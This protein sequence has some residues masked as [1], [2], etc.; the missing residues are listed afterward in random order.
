MSEQDIH[1]RLDR[2][3]FK[4]RLLFTALENVR[5]LQAVRDEDGDVIGLN[6]QVAPPMVETAVR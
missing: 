3:D 4:L 5:V 2:I 6:A 1:A